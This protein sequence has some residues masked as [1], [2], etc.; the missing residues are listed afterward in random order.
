MHDGQVVES[1]SPERII[2]FGVFGIPSLAEH[3]GLGVAM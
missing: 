1:R 3:D 2:G